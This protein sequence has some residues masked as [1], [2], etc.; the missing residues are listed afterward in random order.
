V[1]LFFDTETTGV[2]ANYKAPVTDVLNWPRM[3]QLAV[4]MYDNKERLVFNRSWIIY[5]LS[6]EIP[7]SVSRIHGI[8]TDRART[9]GCL[10][11]YPLNEFAWLLNETHHLVGH[12]IAFDS[13]IVG[14]EYVRCGME[15]PIEL[16]PDSIRKHI[17][18]MESS[19]EFVGIP[20]SLG[21]FKWPKLS[22][23]YL[24]LF[25]E[26]FVGA[27]DASND[28]AATAKCFFELKRLGIIK[29]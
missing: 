17:C 18:T 10:L 9:E 28:V 21:G 3:V 14:C 26:S 7:E 4:E 8:T 15:N 16:K 20:G 1:F 6:Y 24:K 2:P 11:Q 27:H 5:P 22:E 25:N 29:L 12:N 23:L 19:K 13:S